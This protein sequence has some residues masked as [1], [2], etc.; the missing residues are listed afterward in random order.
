LIAWRANVLHITLT[1][2][3]A[4]FAFA[5]LRAWLDHAPL[6]A[7]MAPITGPMYQLFI[8]FMITDPRTV[9]SQ[10]KW[11]IAVA[12][13]IAVV[14]MLI[15]MG[16]DFDLAVARPFAPAPAMFALF[17]VGPIAMWIDLR[18]KARSQRPLVLAPA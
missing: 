17:I 7:E 14:E 6:R 5:P 2:V 8:F 4:F 9:V 11:R 15:R 1:Y 18:A 16:N 12:V 3:A 13:I 10:K